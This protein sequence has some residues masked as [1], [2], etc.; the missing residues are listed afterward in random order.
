[1]KPRLEPGSEEAIIEQLGECEQKLVSL[2]EELGSRDLD[3]IQK[4][5]EDE[6][7]SYIINIFMYNVIK[8]LAHLKYFMCN[9]SVKLL[10]VVIQQTL[11]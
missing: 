5:M 2:V 11:E 8:Y 7:V 6:E 1:M 10:K 9:S 4:E 3:T